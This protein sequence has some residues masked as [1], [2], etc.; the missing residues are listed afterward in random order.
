MKR[1]L[2]ATITVLVLAVG[3]PSAVAL[4]DDDENDDGNDNGATVAT[5]TV[6]FTLTSAMCGYLPRNTTLKGTGTERSVTKIT[7]ARGVTTIRNT[8]NTRGTATDGRHTYRFTYSNS[9]RV[10]NTVA[11]PGS[12]SGRMVDDFAV[13]GNGPVRLHNGFV[14]RL[15]T[16]PDFTFVTWHVL[17]SFGDPISFAA[18][19][20]V[21]H[22]DPL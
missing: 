5:R 16:D 12:F 14:A 3:G 22:C 9:F 1:I 6:E 20:I 18:G 17:S 11:H 21:S 13:S 7:T 15:T 8:T 4:A 10:A 2:I 19:P